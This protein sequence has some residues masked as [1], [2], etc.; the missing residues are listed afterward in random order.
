MID[1]ASTNYH[2]ALLW[3]K[4]N[5]TPE[6]RE[7]IKAFEDADA[8]DSTLTHFLTTL[9]PSIHY[10]DLDIDMDGG[11]IYTTMYF[12]EGGEWLGKIKT[13]RLPL[14]YSRLIQLLR[15]ENPDKPTTAFAILSA[16][17]HDVITREPS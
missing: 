8:V 3:A 16:N 13:D 10:L 1:V 9:I 5:L 6:R 2:D 12:G 7:A 11:C 17:A 14:I 15:E 4:A